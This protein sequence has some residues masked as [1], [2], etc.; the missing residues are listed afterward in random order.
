MSHLNHRSSRFA[1]VLAVVAGLLVT[2]P[3]Q[4]R[5]QDTRYCK[6]VD[7]SPAG[8]LCFAQTGAVTSPVAPTVHTF[9]EGV[10]RA[11]GSELAYITLANYD[12]VPVTVIVRFLVTGI[13]L[14]E[15]EV[16]VKA[17]SR[18]GYEVHANPA[19]GTGLRT[20]SV[21]VYAPD[22]TTDVGLVLRPV[23]DPWSRAILPGD[24][25]QRP[26]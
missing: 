12:L 22:A 16:T 4:A 15:D 19:L 10:V 14:V 8:V 21:R 23:S 18:A 13:G 26:E 9:T 20:F 2:L 5:A 11:P 17:Q 24:T 3:T 1:L 6:S 25:V 7:S